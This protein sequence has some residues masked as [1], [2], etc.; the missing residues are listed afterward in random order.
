MLWQK[1][2][3]ALRERLSES[4]FNLWIEPLQWSATDDKFIELAAPDRFFC[5]WVA[6]H[7]LA[8]IKHCLCSVSGKDQAVRFTVV[9]EAAKPQLL[10]GSE[11]KE[12]LRLPN[13][14]PGRSCVKALHPRYTFDEFMV[15][16]A[17]MLA[18][19]ASMAMASGDSSLG[20]CLYIESET[21]LGKSHLTHSVA[22]HILD[23]SPGTRLHF[24]TAQQLSAEMVRGIMNNSMEQ[25]KEK[26]H[27]QCDV[28]LIEDVHALAGKAKTQ[29]ELAE[30]M[31]VLMESNKLIILT[32][33]LAPKDI[34]DINSGLRSRLSAGLITTINPPDLQTRVLI[35]RKKAE[36]NKLTLSED[37]IYYMAEHLQ[38]DIRKIES[39]IVGIKAKSGL[40]R[41]TPD[42]DMVKEV[43]VNIV[44][45][46]QELS[47]EMI[48]DFLARQFK[49]SVDDMLSKSRKKSVAFPRQVTMYLARKLTEQPL[50]EI[51]KAFNRDHSTVVHSIR[52]VSENMAANGC[53]RG[54]VDLLAKKIEK[55]F[56][57]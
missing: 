10:P 25:F 31:D 23:H 17:N 43:V 5:S 44:G 52:V 48:R 22:H 9:S 20:S 55:Q 36:N 54:Q 50:V 51:G 6:E 35:I 33:A 2:K 29:T 38:G 47:T 34:P 21:G 3:Q 53:V 14:P 8:D 46:H 7:Y 32:G 12:Q 11:I 30:T 56:L 37:L 27:S 42:L 19:S 13:M 18:H 49:V 24:V 1:T 41:T 28:L 26:Y 16:E 15:G 39:A 57:Q 45:R 40:L 4:S